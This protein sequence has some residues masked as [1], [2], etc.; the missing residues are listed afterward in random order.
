M[1]DGGRSVRSAYEQR[2]I[3]ELDI[4]AEPLRLRFDGI[5]QAEEA[6]IARL[7]WG[8]A[9]QQ[10]ATATC[11]ARIVA[12]GAPLTEAELLPRNADEVGWES[13]TLRYR[14]E[15]MREYRTLRAKRDLAAAQARLDDL[16]EQREMEWQALDG[17]LEPIRVEARRLRDLYSLRASVYW[18]GVTTTHRNGR[19]LA[20]LMGRPQL[21]LPPW[22]VGSVRHAGS[23]SGSEALDVDG[24]D[25]D[26][27]SA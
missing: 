7:D 26:R 1:R 10:A 2:L 4:A 18:E 12:A 21:P 9:E 5:R 14:R 17:R 27:R 19:F 6:R 11:E 24:R 20:R 13:E 3:R 8:V 23:A 25:S 22:A 15:V 16:R